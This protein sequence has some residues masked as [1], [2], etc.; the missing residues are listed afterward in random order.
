MEQVPFMSMA[1]V[2][3]KIDQLDDQ[4]WLFMSYD[5]L[6]SSTTL[7]ALVH[8]DLVTLMDEGEIPPAISRLY[9]TN[10]CYLKLDMRTAKEV[11]SVWSHWRDGREAT[12]SEACEAIVFYAEH[13]AYLPVDE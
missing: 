6:V 10:M 12:I 3:M 13:D 9:E 5:K 8:D 7:V 1:D 4:L 11:L 2:I